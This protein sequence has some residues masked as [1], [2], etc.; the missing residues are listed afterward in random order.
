MNHIKIIN[1]RKQEMY[2]YVALSDSENSFTNLLIQFVKGQIDDEVVFKKMKQEI[3]NPG[4]CVTLKIEN[5][6]D[7]LFDMMNNETAI[8]DDEMKSD[9]VNNDTLTNFVREIIRQ[10]GGNDR[11]VEDWVIELCRVEL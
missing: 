4:N 6:D 5:V 1:E 8:F 9:D 11:H 3:D 10:L 7:S 2:A